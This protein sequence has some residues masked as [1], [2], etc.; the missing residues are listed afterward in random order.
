MSVAEVARSSCSFSSSGLSGIGGSR[1]DDDEDDGLGKLDE[2]DAIAEGGG[3]EALSSLV[4]IS[5]HS[6]MCVFNHIQTRVK[7]RE[8]DQFPVVEDDDDEN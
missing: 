3:E 6:L 5:S 8:R 4:L 1:K 2:E 7:S